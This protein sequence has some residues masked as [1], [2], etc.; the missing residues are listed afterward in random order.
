MKQGKDASTIRTIQRLRAREISGKELSKDHRL[1]VVFTLRLRGLGTAAIADLLDY[2]D[3]QVLRLTDKAW[4]INS[5]EFGI[6]SWKLH[7][8]KYIHRMD[9]VIE[10]L[11]RTYNDSNCSWQE[12]IVAAV[13]AGKANTMLTD[14]LQPLGF[15]SVQGA[16]I[17]SKLYNDLGRGEGDQGECSTDDSVRR[18]L[19]A[20]TGL[21]RDIIRLKIEPLQEVVNEKFIELLNVTLDANERCKKQSKELN[22]D[23]ESGFDPKD[24]SILGEK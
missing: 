3:R 16:K 18:K 1:D 9:A 13:N 11:T 21:Q 12:R 10:F 22:S 24:G 23:L 19:E 8:G 4:K 5:H 6:N 20:L 2:S 15:L 7:I 14:T 17:K